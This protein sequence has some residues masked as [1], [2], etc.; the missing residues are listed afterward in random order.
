MRQLPIRRWLYVPLLGLPVTLGCTHTGQPFWIWDGPGKSAAADRQPTGSAVAAAQPAPTNAYMVQSP[1]Q[2]VGTAPATANVVTL[3]LMPPAAAKP[4]PFAGQMTSQMTA[5]SPKPVQGVQAAA[6]YDKAPS[7]VKAPP[8][9][10]PPPV[11]NASACTVTAGSPA[12]G[13]AEDYHW[14]M[15]QVEYSRLGQGWRYGAP[16]EDDPHGG[17]VTLTGDR[18]LRALK[19]GQYVKVEGSLLNPFDKGRA[20]AYRVEAFQVIE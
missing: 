19:D 12:F 17:S 3:M 7:I 6:C 4:S 2:P 13:R 8:V 5:P 10:N 15:G 9:M 14:L 11:V 1:P 16:G 20:P 18:R